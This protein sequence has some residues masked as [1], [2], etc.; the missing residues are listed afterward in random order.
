[1]LGVAHDV[2]AIDR[3]RGA[4]CLH[5]YHG[6]MPREFSTQRNRNRVKAAVASQV[7]A[8]CS[9]M[10]SDRA[11][12]LHAVMFDPIAVFQ[13]HFDHAISKV[14]LIVITAVAFNNRCAAELFSNDQHARKCGV[15]GLTAAGD[16][17]KV[18]WRRY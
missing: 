1:M 15:V 11:L 6:V 12:V 4:F 9:Y 10:I 18:D 7:S 5:D 16:K 14:W 8:R 13:H 17:R 2:E 3:A